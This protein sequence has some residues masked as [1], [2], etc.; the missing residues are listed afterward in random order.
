VTAPKHCADC[1]HHR[2][3]PY[4]IKPW[5]RRFRVEASPDAKAC[6]HGEKAAPAD[7]GQIA[8]WGSR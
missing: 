2:M 4:R 5:C 8:A 6:G 3:P 7:D 1:I